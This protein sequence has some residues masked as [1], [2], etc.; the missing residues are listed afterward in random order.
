S[1]KLKSSPQWQRGGRGVASFEESNPDDELLRLSRAGARAERRPADGGRGRSARRAGAAVPAAGR[2][3]RRQQI[4]AP[5]ALPSAADRL[6]R[7][8]R[9]DCLDRLGHVDRRHWPAWPCGG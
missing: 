9:L 1:P 6:D 5:P 7:L 2:R 8:A 3:I 4:T